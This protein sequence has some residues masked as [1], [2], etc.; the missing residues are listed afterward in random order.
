MGSTKISIVTHTEFMSVSSSLCVFRRRCGA[1]GSSPCAIVVHCIINPRSMLRAQV[2]GHPVVRRA[3]DSCSSGT[4]LPTAQFPTR[5]QGQPR[6]PLLSPR[7]QRPRPGLQTCRLAATSVSRKCTRSL[8]WLRILVSRTLCMVCMGPAG[9]GHALSKLN[10]ATVWREA[11]RTRSA[12]AR[13]VG[14]LTHT[15]PIFNI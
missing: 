1:R 7:R 5:R 9:A 15:G 12:S 10:G 14:H 3:A 2:R 4:L 8:R 6:L 13:P 11:E